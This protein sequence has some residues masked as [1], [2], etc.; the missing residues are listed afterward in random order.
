MNATIDGVVWLPVSLAGIIIGLPPSKTA[1]A[2]FPVPKSIE[3]VFSVISL[4]PFN[5]HI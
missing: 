5:C 2:L 1:T 3:I 4:L